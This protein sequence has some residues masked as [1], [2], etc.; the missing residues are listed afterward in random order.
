MSKMFIAL[1]PKDIAEKIDDGFKFF[2]EL[3]FTM[4]LTARDGFHNLTTGNKI[5]K[6]YIHS[7]YGKYKL[8]L[9][10]DSGS[11]VQDIMDSHEVAHTLLERRTL[12]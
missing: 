2:T 12:E 7:Y 4:S 5:Y 11:Y 1:R 3:E 6:L 9:T 10:E 8:N